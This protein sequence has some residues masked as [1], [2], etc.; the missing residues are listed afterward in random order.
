[1]E[2][3]DLADAGLQNFV[4]SPGDGSHV[5]VANRATG[6]PAK[7]QVHQRVPIRNGHRLSVDAQQHPRLE[8][9]SGVDL[10]VRVDCDKRAANFYQ[11]FISLH[12]LT[13]TEGG[14]V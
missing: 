6:V 12:A 2:N 8:D 3:D 9:I 1:V 14:K 10:V 4:I 13:T 5:E 11:R 7:L